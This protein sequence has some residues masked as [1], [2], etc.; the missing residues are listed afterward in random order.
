MKCYVG[1]SLGAKFIQ[2]H[3]EENADSYWLAKAALLKNMTIDRQVILFIQYAFAS[4]QMDVQM[5][6]LEEESY[7]KDGRLPYDH[8][9]TWKLKI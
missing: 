7:L 4:D 9:A 2:I 8:N 5:I 3:R 6:Q 1:Q